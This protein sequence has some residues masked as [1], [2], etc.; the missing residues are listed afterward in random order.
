MIVTHHT[1]KGGGKKYNSLKKAKCLA[2]FKA[3]KLYDIYYV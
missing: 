2:G 1:L 3:L